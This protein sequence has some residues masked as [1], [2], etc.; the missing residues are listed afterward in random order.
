MIQLQNNNE[1]NHNDVWFCNTK[2]HHYELQNSYII[3]FKI[4][5]IPIKRLSGLIILLK[6]RY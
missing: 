4:N 6:K 2:I 5:N 3:I 1:N